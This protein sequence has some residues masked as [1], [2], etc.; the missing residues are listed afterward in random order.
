MSE[1]QHGALCYLATPYSKW[2][3]G[4]ED[5]FIEASK[6]AAL[7]L[8]A[9]VKV[10]SPIAH[11]HPLAIHGNLD[12]LDHNI[13]LPFDE[14]MMT[15]AQ[16]LIVAH[17]EGWQESKGI[18]HEIKFFE[19]A[20]KPIWDL[21]PANMVMAK[22]KRLAPARDRYEDL[23]DDQIRQQTESF[24]AHDKTPSQHGGSSA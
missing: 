3:A 2:S 23:T 17:M 19:A 6:L 4:L 9:G 21:N 16:V 15:A 1:L 12:P 10:Y 24:L 22:R 20:K 8:R 14:A 13:W 11:T 7:L 18:A 5:A